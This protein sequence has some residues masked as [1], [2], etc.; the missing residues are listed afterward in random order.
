MSDTAGGLES[1]QG[2]GV[3]APY[4]P[5]QGPPVPTQAHPPAPN[6]T[7]AE[8]GDWSEARRV[9]HFAWQEGVTATKLS[10]RRC[11]ASIALSVLFS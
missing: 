5:V 7:L 2:E 8:V 3:G 6:P 10:C 9:S 11:F 1:W 4:Q